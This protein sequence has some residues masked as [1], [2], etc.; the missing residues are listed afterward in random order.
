VDEEDD[1]D[2]PGWAQCI[3]TTVGC[4]AATAFVVALALVVVNAGMRALG[5]L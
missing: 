2:E 1:D 4:L 5:W 3:A